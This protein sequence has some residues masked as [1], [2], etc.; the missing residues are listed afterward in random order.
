MPRLRT[1]FNAYR[2]VNVCP[3]LIG[4][5]W[6]VEFFPSSGSAPT[7]PCSVISIITASGP[8]ILLFE[9]AGCRRLR[10]AEAILCARPL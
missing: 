1:A 6:V 5:S 9:K 8:F 4:C 3:A 10:T 7:Q 2:A